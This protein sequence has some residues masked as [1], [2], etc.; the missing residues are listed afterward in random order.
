MVHRVR[1]RG[2]H[3]GRQ[4]GDDLVQH[5]RQRRQTADRDAFLERRA[6]LFEPQSIEVGEQTC[7][8]DRVLAAPR[9]V[10]VADQ[11]VLGAGHS[12]NGCDPLQVFFRRGAELQ[13]EVVD[14]AGALPLHEPGHLV[15][16][17]ERHRDVQRHRLVQRS[18]KEH[19]DGPA[20]R[21]PEDVP[22][23]DIHGALRG[24][25]AA[26]GRSPCVR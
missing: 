8:D 11:S 1:R 26:Q 5:D 17:S 16:W 25:L 23:R 6:R 2:P 9:S 24:L 13:L 3:E 20:R 19:R 21:V 7:R 10:G 22:A 14:P 4:V 18:T 12:V 15:G